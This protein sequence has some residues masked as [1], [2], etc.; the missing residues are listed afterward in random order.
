MVSQGQ[1]APVSWL[2]TGVYGEEEPLHRHLKS[3]WT[4]ESV[5]GREYPK[6]PLGPSKPALVN[7]QDFGP[8]YYCCPTKIFF[9]PPTMSQESQESQHPPIWDKVSAKTRGYLA[10][11]QRHREEQEQQAKA[12]EMS[13]SEQT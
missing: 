12:S 3:P 6:H 2:N 11:A 1:V 13:A 4:P 9:F 10:Q 8:E 7:L 5:S